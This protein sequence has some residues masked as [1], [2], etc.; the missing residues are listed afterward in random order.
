MELYLFFVFI[1]FKEYCQANG[2][3]NAR[4]YE[5]IQP[6]DLVSRSTKW[7]KLKRTAFF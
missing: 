2:S 5:D 3:G 7:P 4:I 1:S 6:H